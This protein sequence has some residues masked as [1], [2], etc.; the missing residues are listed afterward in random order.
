[1]TQMT[2]NSQRAEGSSLPKNVKTSVWGGGRLEGLAEPQAWDMV[3]YG[4]EWGWCEYSME[5]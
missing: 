5:F 4:G 2:A 1:M 3:S